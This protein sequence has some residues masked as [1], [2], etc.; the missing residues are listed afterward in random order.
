MKR[1]LSI[2]LVVFIV[3]SSTL[4]VFANP[5]TPDPTLPSFA[6]TMRYPVSTSYNI[7]NWYLYGEDKGNGYGHVG[8]DILTPEGSTVKAAKAGTIEKIYEYGVDGFS[9]YGNYIVINHGNNLRTLYA[10]LKSFK[11]GLSEGDSIAENAE[12]AKSG[13]TGGS[14]GPHLHFEVRYNGSTYGYTLNPEMCLNVSYYFYGTIYG[15]VYNSSNNSISGA[16]I[17]GLSKPTSVVTP[18]TFSSLYT[19][20]RPDPSYTTLTYVRD[21]LDFDINYC[22]GQLS[23]GSYTVTYSESGYTSSSSSVYLSTFNFTEKNK[24]L[25]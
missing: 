4:N 6:H 19:Y 18:K 9:S 13:N 17:S 10:H 24:V 22:T 20:L 21:V 12:I 8:I 16:K 3:T 14:T 23:T 11:T 15:F 7:N 1:F 25:Y 2:F 5:P